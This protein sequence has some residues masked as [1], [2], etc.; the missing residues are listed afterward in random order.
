MEEEDV[1]FG[2]YLALGD[3]DLN[4]S[5]WVPFTLQALITEVVPRGKAAWTCS[6]LG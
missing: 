3:S 2:Q 5:N 6:L 4:S 1:L